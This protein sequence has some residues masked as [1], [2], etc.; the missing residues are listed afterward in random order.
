MCVSADGV[1]DM[2][3]TNMARGIAEVVCLWLVDISVAKRL[4]WRTDVS[5][6]SKKRHVFGVLQKRCSGQ[7]A[8]DMRDGEMER[9]LGEAANPRNYGT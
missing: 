9:G 1:C 7:S 8:E 5:G 4:H 3:V 2:A 6:E